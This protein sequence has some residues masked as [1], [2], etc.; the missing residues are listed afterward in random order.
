VMRFADYMDIIEILANGSTTLYNAQPEQVLGKPVIFSDSTVKPII[1]DFNYA[2][3]NYDGDLV[4]DSDKD[5]NKGEYLFVLTAWL[6][7]HLLLKS[8]F[9]IANVSI[10]ATTSKKAV[11]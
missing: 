6:D 8:A 7:M 3:L 4:Y 2:H 5:V 10:P 11:S 1:G 9:R